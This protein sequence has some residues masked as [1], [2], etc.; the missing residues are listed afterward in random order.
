M[1]NKKHG[2]GKMFYK[3]GKIKY[4]GDFV[5]D[6]YEGYGQYNL[7]NGDYYTGEWANGLRHGNGAFYSK[8]KLRYKGKFE[9]DYFVGKRNVDLV[10]DKKE[11]GEKEK[12]RK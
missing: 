5:N 3:N 12:K 6:R 2:N 8:G 9:N 11:E 1:N 7:E 10:D 4:D